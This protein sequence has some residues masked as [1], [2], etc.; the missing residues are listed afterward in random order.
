[1]HGADLVEQAIDRLEVR[2]SAV[3]TEVTDDAEVTF[4]EQTIEHDVELDELLERVPLGLVDAHLDGR[5]QLGGHLGQEALITRFPMFQLYPQDAR[6][7]RASLH[8]GHG[9]SIRAFP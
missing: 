7:Q 6:R 9:P 2:V 1:V 3:A 8:V 5:L 4:S